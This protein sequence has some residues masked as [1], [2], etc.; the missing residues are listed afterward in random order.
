MLVLGIDSSAVAASA[1]VAEDGRLLGEF[2]MNTKQ[3]HSQTLLP[4]VEQ[5]LKSSQTSLA[6]LDLLAVAA[7]PGSFTGLRISMAAVKGMA[8]GADKPCAGVSTLEALAWN[9]RGFAGTAAAVMDARCQQVYCALFR[10][11]GG[12]VS[13]LT[14]D[15]ACSLEELGELLENAPKPVFLVGDG[16]MLCY[17]TLLERLPD[18]RPAPA[19]LRFQRA[20]SVGALALRAAARGETV[21]CQELT[22][23]YLRLPQAQRELLAR[24]EMSTKTGG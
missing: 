7:G 15:G 2:Y 23:S 9:L 4:M 10:L 24:Q 8:L 14:P 19:H 5:L 20:S 11:E 22:P 17:N 16:A 18:L 21:S 1:A 6:D 13:R 3:T 12:E